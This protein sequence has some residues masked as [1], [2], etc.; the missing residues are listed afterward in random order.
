MLYAKRRYKLARADDALLACPA[1]AKTGSGGP[2]PTTLMM[3]TRSTKLDCVCV[4]N[5]YNYISD[6]LYLA[7]IE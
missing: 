1:R 6:V 7:T 3:E 4:F 2:I 5:F